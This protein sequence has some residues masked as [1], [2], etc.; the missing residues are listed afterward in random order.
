MTRRDIRP[1]VLLSSLVLF[2]CADDSIGGAGGLGTGAET[3]DTADTQTSNDETA[4][5]SASGDGDGDPGD[6]DAGD[7]DPS[8]AGDGDGDPGDGDPGDGDGDS[9]DGDSGD[10]DSGDG[11]SGDGDGGFCGDGIIDVGEECDD[12]VDNNGD[13]FACLSDCVLNICGDG[14]EGPE[15][16]CDDG[17]VM[18]GDGCS[19]ICTIENF[20]PNSIFCGNKIYECG[21]TIDND[22]DGLVDLDDPECTTPC[23]DDESSFLTNL[24]G[25]NADCKSDCYWDGD[26]GGGNDSCEWNLKCDPENPGAGTMC[27]Y[28]Q[29]L[30]MCELIQPLLCYDVC[31]PLV[32]NGCDCFGCC[33][34]AGSL[35]YLGNGNCTLD[36]L[37]AC[38]SCTQHEECVNTCEPENCE[39]CFGQDIDDLPIECTETECPDDV[40]PCADIEEDCPD[41]EFCQTGCCVPIE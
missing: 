28:D 1:I 25:Q 7:G 38:E 23:D 8:D 24:P 17:N 40:T 13:V 34:V 10:G 33:D 21:D 30:M 3:G 2:A 4:S 15:E 31:A 5:N 35:I 18:G 14:F 6:G 16:G 22:M 9:G 20:D 26:S 12:G 41:G 39:L 36:N 32:P 11:D 19:M 27:E 37:Y 29:N